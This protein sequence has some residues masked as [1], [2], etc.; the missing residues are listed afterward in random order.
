MEQLP[1]RGDG[2]AGQKGG[3]KNEKDAWEWG[4]RQ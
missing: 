4:L 3:G 2:E 1:Q